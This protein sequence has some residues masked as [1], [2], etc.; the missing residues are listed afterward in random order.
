MPAV[1]ASPQQL[2]QFVVDDDL[3]AAVRA[4]L[5][6]YTASPGEATLSPAQSQLLLDA[7]QRLRI[8][9]AARERHRARDARM[10]RR[11]AEREARRAP[12]PVANSKPALPSAAAAILARAKARAAEKPSS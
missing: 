8:A 6:D 4:G 9:W 1:S 12:P 3:D 7:Q 11:A 2:L 5:M 10:A